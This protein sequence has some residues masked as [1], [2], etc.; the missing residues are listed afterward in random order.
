MTGS[1]WFTLSLGRT[2]RAE[3]RWVLPLI[4][5]AGGITRDD[6]GSIKIFDDETRF[7]ISAEKAAQFAERVAR[8]GSGEKGVTISPAGQNAQQSAHEPLREQGF[9]PRKFEGQGRTKP[10]GEHTAMTEPGADKTPKKAAWRKDKPYKAKSGGQ[11][12]KPRAPDAPGRP[13]PAEQR[14][15]KKS[16][17]GRKPGPRVA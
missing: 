1:A 7:Q 6:V 9:K 14:K 10:A 4:C 2:H 8:D 17:T 12:G 3:P 11:P 5:K 15:Q 16:K 13:H